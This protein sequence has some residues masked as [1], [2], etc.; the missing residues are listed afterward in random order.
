SKR[1]ATEIDLATDN[2]ALITECKFAH[3]RIHEAAISLI[4]DEQKPVKHRQIGQLLLQSTPSE[5][6]EQN[7]FAIVDQLN[8]GLALIKQQSERDELAKLNLIAGKKAKASAAY[9]PAFDYLKVGIELLGE[10]SWHTQYKLTL[11]LHEEAAEAAYLSSGDFEQMEQWVEV[12]LQQAKTVL[13][14][15]KAYEVKIQAYQAQNQA[16]KALDTG[17]EVLDKLGIKFPK[18][19]KKW[20]ILLNLLRTKLILLGKRTEDLINLPEMTEPE[21]I[22]A[23]RIM[24]K[25]AIYAY[26][27]VAE[28]FVLIV[29]KMVSLSLKYGNASESALGYAGYA[30]ILCG[31]LEDIESSY[32]FGEIALKLWHK[33]NAKEYQAKVHFIIYALIRPWKNHLKE[34]II[35]LEETFQ[36]GLDTGD[37]EFAGYA[38][39]SSY[40]FLH[41]FQELSETKEKFESC[42][43][44]I[45]QLR[46]KR[47]VRTL[48]IYHQTNL[49]LL[50]RSKRASQLIS[51][52]DEIMLDINDRTDFVRLSYNKLILCC[53][54]DFYSEAIEHV[55]QIEKYLYAMKGFPYVPIFHLYCSLVRL[56]LYKTATKPEQRQY[57]KKVRANQKKMKNWAHHAPMNYLHKFYLVE[58][59]WHRVIG[60]DA[61]AMDFYD[62]AIELAIENEYLNEE[63]LAYELAAKF[64]MANGREDC[65]AGYFRKAHYAYTRW[66]AL[67]KVKHLEENYP[68]KFFENREPAQN[69]IPPPGATI[70]QPTTLLDLNSVL[71]ASQAIASEMNE[72]RL[73]E[74]L[75]K[76]VIENAGAQRGVLIL[77]KD[78]QWFIE[79]EGE[80]DEMTVLQSIPLSQLSVTSNQ[81]SVPKAIIDY[82]VRTKE[83]VV[84]SDATQEGQFTREPYIVAHQVKSVLCVPLLKQDNVKGLLYLENNQATSVFTQERE[85]VLK[86]LSSQIVISIENARH[87]AEMMN[88]N[89]EYKRK[90]A[91]LVQQ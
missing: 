41:L 26:V 32:Q 64:Y 52:Y 85:E 53:L 69:R 55:V 79:A 70:I 36:S 84:L 68:K 66:G 37:L 16:K 13:D 9:Q 76:I 47:S 49:N 20:H 39:I 75:M 80:I 6:R 2:W 82:V 44:V 7:I 88:Q 57:R 62:K 81:L 19:P 43:E 91:E 89:L 18:F 40:S 31:H 34:S 83:N 59:E 86:L 22:A 24:D 56:A 25:T 1:L 42:T 17:L 38:I 58:A 27:T 4:P 28:F 78:G 48:R 12:V 8:V 29:L 11:S 45:S 23:M 61:K 3:D 72:R 15:V 30:V 46:Q 14:K 10:D 73:L 21:Q 63:A 74:T 87:H 77:D 5:E 60:Q 33:F 65:A 67:A 35:P 51:S 90:I 54:F 50:E 71:K